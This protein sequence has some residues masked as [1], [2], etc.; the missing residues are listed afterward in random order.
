[1]ENKE[2]VIKGKGIKVNVLSGIFIAIGVVTMIASILVI[3]RIYDKY[4]EMVNSYQNVE[5]QS[6]AAE[7]FQKASDYLTS[8]S[9]QFAVTYDI[10]N[11]EN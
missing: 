4:D 10:K 7:S 2:I 3:K 11:A 1:M 6:E 5:V 8:Q 9:R